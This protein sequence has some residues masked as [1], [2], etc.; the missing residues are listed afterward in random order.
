M[1]AVIFILILSLLVIIHELGH[2]LAAKRHG[3]EVKEFGL[4]YPPRL[5][6]LFKWRGTLFSLNAIPFGG[7][8]QMSG[9]DGPEEKDQPNAFYHKSIRARLEVLLAGV[10]FNFVFGILA[11]AVVFYQLGIPAPLHNQARIQEIIADSPAAAAGLQVNTNILA[12]QVNQEW[13]QISSMKQVQDIVQNHAGE[14]LT[15]RSSLA[16][17]QEICPTEFTEHQVYLRTAAETPEGQGSMGIAFT[18]FVF[19]TYPWYLM[20]VMTVAHAFEQ[21]LALAGLIL[22]A[23]GE[24]MR[25]LVLGR[26]VQQEIAGP[27]GI[28]DQATTYGFFDGGWLSVV[29]FAALLSINLGIMN[30]LPIPALDGGR[31]VLVMMEKLVKRSKLDRV[32]YYL[33]YF[34]YFSLLALMLLVS[35]ND[36][37]N[38]FR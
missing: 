35:F 37:R 19:K 18:E 26:G 21:S 4:G 36:I 1:V 20:P 6:S 30:L 27:I 32:S 13:V 31:A 10:F 14:T 24:L 23:L 9:E 5:L 3:I 28:V 22:Q 11:F 17:E 16:C 12:I 25:D 38:L 34:G 8:V 7:F 33:N 2:F 29:N 15:I